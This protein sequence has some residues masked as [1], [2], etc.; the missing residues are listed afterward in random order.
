MPL[1]EQID[2]VSEEILEWV[3]TFDKLA[4]LA[5]ERLRLTRFEQTEKEN[6]YHYSVSLEATNEL[7][8][9]E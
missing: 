3:E 4:V 8:K 1:K 2:A 7:A 9:Q 5:R 6:R